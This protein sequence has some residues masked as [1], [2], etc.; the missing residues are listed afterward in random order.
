M[1][2]WLGIYGQTKKDT[3]KDEFTRGIR[4]PIIIGSQT[5]VY[6]LWW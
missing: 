2:N 3:F 4:K 6:N 5:K 1:K